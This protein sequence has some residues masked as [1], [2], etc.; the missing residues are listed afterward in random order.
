MSNVAPSLS[1]PQQ[2][3][4][5]LLCKYIDVFGAPIL[6]LYGPNKDGHCSC[7]KDK[8]CGKNQFKH[9][10]AGLCPKGVHSATTDKSRILQWLKTGLSLNWGLAT[11]KPLPGGDYLVVLD[12]DPRNGSDDTLEDLQA[13]NGKLPRTP[14]QNTGG[15][16]QHYVFR[17]D[18]DTPTS[19]PGAGL[20]LKGNGGY[21]V[22]EPSVHYSGNS[23]IWDSGLDLDTPIAEAPEWIVDSKK[24]KPRPEWTGKKAKDS[25]IGA[26]F[27]YAGWLGHELSE[28]RH[29]VNCPWSNLHTD[30]RGKGGDASSVILPP[31]EESQAGG[32]KCQHSHCVNKTWKDA[33]EALPPD[34]RVAA[35]KKFQVASAPI[36][37]A[38]PGHVDL[39]PR[40]TA[41]LT[42]EDL[43]AVREHLQF[44]PTDGSLKKDL[45][46]VVEILR[47]DPRWKGLLS[48]DNFSHQI[49]LNRE[50]MWHEH[51]KR[52]G[53]EAKYPR[54]WQ[55]E[56]DIRAK[57]WFSRFW[58]LDVERIVVNEAV[59]ALAQAHG[60]HP[61]RQYLRGLEWDGVPRVDT[62][63]TKYCEVV[64]TEYTRN[65]GRW[66]L[67]SA[68]ARVMNPGC[69]ADHVLILEGAQGIGKSTAFNILGGEWVCDSSIT[70]GDKDAYQVIRGR[71]IV[72]LAELDSLNKADASRAK[73]FFTSPTDTYRPSY[74]RAVISVPRQVVFCGTVNHS[75]FLKDETGSRRYWPVL[76]HAINTQQLR[77][78]RDQIWAE[79]LR[80]YNSGHR[81]W[82]QGTTEQ[83]QCVDEQSK[84]EI[85]DEWE[86]VVRRWLDGPDAIAELKDTGF[87]TI[88]TILAGALKIEAGRWTPNDMGR[89]GRC[90]QRLGWKKRRKGTDWAFEKDD[91]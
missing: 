61:V 64:D 57:L 43:H 56:D 65:V 31:T 17:V 35:R 18:R 32:F 25:I 80:L 76:C 60:V 55:D 20:D 44:K 14:M 90:M 21:I 84:R 59:I 23:Y 75:Q 30:G 49:L 86:V 15:G 70:I 6:A 73:A 41:A 72:E 88:G 62:W 4:Y 74:G 8:D 40:V 54:Q 82:P 29:A 27:E 33:M 85:S 26:A 51:D 69:K 63:L 66:W 22:V 42:P 81:W 2:T 67:I 52:G 48:Y 37:A 12:C 77:V 10:H 45:V 87:I 7:P 28:G 9:P 5:D 47:H 34:A 39:K 3:T 83:A 13:T 89:V 79:A 19:K 24:V 1:V 16:G 78:D 68:I 71:W 50:P 36:V 11:G 38:G 58:S 53:Y 91:E 46:N